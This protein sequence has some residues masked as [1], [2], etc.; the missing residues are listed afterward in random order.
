MSVGWSGLLGAGL[1]RQG[2]KSEGMLILLLV[3]MKIERYSIVQ[4]SLRCGEE[5]NGSRKEFT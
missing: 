5:N 1:V 2:R 3:L 4:R